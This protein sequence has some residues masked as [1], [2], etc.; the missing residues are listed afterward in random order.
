MIH[1]NVFGDIHPTVWER[2]SLTCESEGFKFHYRNYSSESDWS[3]CIGNA[4][5]DFPFDECKNKIFM[6]LEPPEV[7]NYGIEFLQRFTF[8]VGP[9]FQE[10]SNLSNYRFSNVCHPWSVG[11]LFQDTKSDLKSKLI[12]KIPSRFQKVFLEAPIV[13]FS[14]KDLLSMD[15]DKTKMLS[16]ITSNKTDTPMQ[17]ER[18]A[19][20]QYLQKRRNIPLEVFGRGYLPIRDKFEILKK[21]T[22]HL[23]LENSSHMGNWTEKL[24]DSILALNKTYYVGAPQMNDYFSNRIVQP[25]ELSD[26][27]KAEA[28]IVE[29]FQNNELATEE[30]FE[31]RIK[32]VFEYSFESVVKK[33]INSEINSQ[34]K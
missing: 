18:I 7:Y 1:V 13:A 11:L 25:I 32:L 12:R 2:Q 5:F 26:F 19:F 28:E 9:N 21:S 3:I 20:I 15:F 10:Y 6:L 8:V 14:I 27:E 29:D 31:A 16:V 30:I 24:S 4:G 23:A 33:L 22:H 17:R 34:E